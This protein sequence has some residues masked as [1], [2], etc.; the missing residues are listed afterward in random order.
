MAGHSE[1]PNGEPAPNSNDAFRYP[2]A[3]S[4]LP[5][6]ESPSTSPATPEAVIGAPSAI[7]TFAT[8]APQIANENDAPESDARAWRFAIKAR[9]RRI[10]WNARQR[11]TAVLVASVVIAGALGA[12]IGSLATGFSRAPAP[13]IDVA[14][15]EERKAMEKSIAHLSKEVAALKTDLEA[16]NK[17]ARSQVAKLTARLPVAPEITGSVPM[18]KAPPHMA[19]PIPVPRPGPRIAS[20]ESRPAVRPTLMTSWTIRSAREGAVY[21]ERHGEIFQ[22]SVGAPLPGLGRVEAIRRQ[23]GRWMVVTPK[24][25]I[26]SQRDR[27]YFETF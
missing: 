27:R 2:A 4:E 11:R 14:A 25:I 26:V 16:A 1:E 13:R 7:E 21:V 10:V 8:L 24:G 15:V 20:L 22:V 18:P 5:A 3:R 19:A 17:A 23:E 9:R 6:V 12:V